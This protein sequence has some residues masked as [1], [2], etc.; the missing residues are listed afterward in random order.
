MKFGSG[1]ENVKRFELHVFEHGRHGLGLVPEADGDLTAR[2]WTGLCE[3][4]LR[5]QGF[6]ASRPEPIDNSNFTGLIFV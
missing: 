1:S 4:W 5:K 6:Q 2:A 3:T